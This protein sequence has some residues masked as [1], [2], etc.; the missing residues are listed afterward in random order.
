MKNILGLIFLAILSLSL[1]NCSGRGAS[2]NLP[3]KGFDSVFNNIIVS[4][5]PKARLLVD[6]LEQSSA[7]SMS[8]CLAETY[9]AICNLAEYKL[10]SV[11]LICDRVEKILSRQSIGK[12]ERY[13]IAMRNICT[14]KG[15]AYSYSRDVDL[16]T[17]YLKAA[18]G[19]E[20]TKRLPQAYLNLADNY[21]QKGQYVNAAECYR[22]A[23]QINDSLGKI[24][25]PDLIYN[26]LA[27]SYI[28]IS[29]FEDAEKNLDK[30]KES[31][32]QMSSYDKYI[33]YN[34]YGNLPVG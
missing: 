21:N 23:L 2:Q 28:N 25:R 5:L 9:R 24:V 17:K 16:A 7:D 8:Q 30:A 13:R 4:N 29:A 6:S 1:Y 15:I 33:L 34:N 27:M 18:I 22:R 19:F 11:H 32:S 12:T 26:G 3:A 20:E 14:A 31:L 10:D